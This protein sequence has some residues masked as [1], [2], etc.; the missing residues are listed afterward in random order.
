MPSFQGMIRADLHFTV[1]KFSSFWWPYGL[2]LAPCGCG[3]CSRRFRRNWLHLQEWRRMEM[4]RISKMRTEIFFLLFIFFWMITRLNTLTVLRSLHADPEDGGRII[5]L[6]VA[7]TAH[8]Y[9]VTAP[10][11]HQ[12]KYS[13][14]IQQ[15]EEMWSKFLT[16]QRISYRGFRGSKQMMILLHYLEI[17]CNHL[18]HISAGVIVYSW[19][20]IIRLVYSNSD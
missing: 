18:H 15:C 4:H 8:S 7:N 19:S 17:Y 9:T 16:E 3:L 6:S 11:Q 5:F 13:R 2:D 1:Y 10:D 14:V 12:E 20:W